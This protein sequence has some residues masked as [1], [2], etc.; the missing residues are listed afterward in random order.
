MAMDILSQLQRDEATRL[1]PYLDCCGKPWRQCT[2]AKKGK[3]T[4]GI[5]RNL[6]DNGIRS[7]EA[8]VMEQNDVDAVDARLS[9]RLP[10]TNQLDAARR[11][12]LLNMAFNMGIGGLLQFHNMLAAVQ[13]GDWAKAAAEM[14]ESTWAKQVG[15]RAD[16]LEQQM[17]T[18][19]WV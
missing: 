13:A 11:G 10:W 15:A 8:L 9:Q 1:F 14:K 4:I 18:G 17:L 3:L 6:D 16:R 5:G 7:N 19:Q 2:C 12:V